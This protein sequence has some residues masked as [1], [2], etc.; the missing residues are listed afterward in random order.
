MIRMMDLRKSNTFLIILLCTISILIAGCADQQQNEDNNINE[1]ETQAKIVEIAQTFGPSDSLDP[2]SRWVGWYVREAGLYETLFSYD[3]NMEMI[4]ELATGY[5]AINDTAWQIALRE[6]VTF[7]DGTPMTSEAV[8]YSINRVQDPDNTRSSQYDF[9]EDVQALDDYTVLITTEKPYAPAIASLTDPIV[10][11]VNPEATDLAVSP[12]GTGPYAFESFEPGIELVVKKNNNY[13]SG[14]PQLDVAVFNYVSDPVTRSLKLEGGDVQIAD[15]IPPAEVARLDAK[16]GITIYNEETMRTG[17]MYVNT[18]KAPLDDV[19]VRQA[20]NHAI[21]REQVIDAALEGVGGSPA[22]GVFPSLFSWS[23][24]EQLDPYDH[25]PEKALEML[26]QAG[27]EDEDGDG[28]LDYAG[29]PFSLNIKTY[30]SRPEMKPAAE[31]MAA[32]FREIGIESEAIILESGAL[33]ADM[34]DGNYDL[35]LYAWGVAPT[36]DPDYFLSQHFASDSKYAGWTGYSNE[37]VDEWL[38][39]GRTTMDNDQRLEYYNNIQREVFED[40]PEI[41]VFYYRKTV[42]TSDEIQGFTIYPNEITFLTEDV[43]LE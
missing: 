10:S 5:E 30:A 3:E 25:N 12:C 13:W 24:N 32:Q 35:G 17:F 29:E 40:C 36:G 1:N 41:F 6:N 33:S 21:N 39:L 26:A 23:A 34:S 15:G 38:E 14:Q 16:D 28:T 19:R 9:I 7:H 2:S 22:V 42:G 20:I 11:I 31:A 27:I 4:P 37:N 18:R 43:R 8:V